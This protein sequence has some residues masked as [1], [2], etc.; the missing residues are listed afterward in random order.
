MSIIR[1]TAR[2]EGRKGSRGIITEIANRLGV[3]RQAV[4]RVN[5]NPLKSQRIAAALE[6]YQRT[7]R[8]PQPANE[9]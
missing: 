1:V 3:S 7:G 8:L 9:Q 2:N 4:S 5:K 6:L